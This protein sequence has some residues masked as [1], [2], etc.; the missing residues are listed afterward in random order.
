MRGA[1]I[2]IRGLGWGGKMLIAARIAFSFEDVMMALL[3]T[4]GSNLLKG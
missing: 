4:K 3:G 1:V 2:E